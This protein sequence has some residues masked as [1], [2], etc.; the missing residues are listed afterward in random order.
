MG[1]TGFVVLLKFLQLLLLQIGL[2][3]GLHT[4][5][6]AVNSNRNCLLKNEN[7]LSFNHKMLLTY[8]QHP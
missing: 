8:A 4:V 7:G 5:F 1:N 3:T 2:L 6:I